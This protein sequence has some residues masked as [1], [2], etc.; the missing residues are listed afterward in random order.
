MVASQ[1]TLVT[2]KWSPPDFQIPGG[3]DYTCTCCHPDISPQTLYLPC[4]SLTGPDT[5]PSS[6][7]VHP[8]PGLLYCLSHQVMKVS[9]EK[10]IMTSSNKSLY[11]HLVSVGRTGL[12]SLTLVRLR[13]HTRLDCDYHWLLF[14]SL[15]KTVQVWRHSRDTEHHSVLTGHFL[16]VSTESVHCWV[17]KY[18]L[19][20]T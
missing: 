9:R 7:L 4:S 15:E 14:G 12:V 20:L 17:V 5:L 18:F 1:V 3:E 16:K 2:R 8:S 19:L 6:T 13:G 11:M 10:I